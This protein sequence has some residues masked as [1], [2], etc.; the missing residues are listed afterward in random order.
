MIT[1]GT[2]GNETTAVNLFLTYDGPAAS[3]EPQ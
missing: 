3:A 1:V 2:R